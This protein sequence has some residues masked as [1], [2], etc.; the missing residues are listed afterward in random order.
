M[1]KTMGGS[2]SERVAEQII[3]IIKEKGLK[4]GERLVNEYE[5]AN[6][7]GVSRSTVRESIKSLESRNILEIRQGAG[8][9]VSEK[10]GIPVD[11]LGLTF[12]EWDG[13]LALDLIEARLM[14]EPQ[15]AEAA[16]IRATSE[17]INKIM[18]QCL[19]VE[20]LIN[21]NQEYREEDMKFHAYIAEASGN[22][23]IE[24]LIP[25]IN[26]SVSTNID[27]THNE[28]VKHTVKN[29]REIAEAIKR[30]DYIGA[31]T[32]MVEHLHDNRML[33]ILNYNLNNE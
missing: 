4:P 1:K 11:P 5:L 27:A 19:K 2:L 18:E 30:H 9:F 25:I 33:I 28:L 10:Q 22:K 3:N 31:K 14:L 7:L 15:I 29:H 13:K 12:E 8:T 20:S 16:A 26:S 24:K 23:I 21:T 32:A 6:Q 17:Q